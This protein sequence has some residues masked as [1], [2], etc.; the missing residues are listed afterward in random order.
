VAAEGTDEPVIDLLE[1]EWASISAL[2]A[3]LDDA[4][5][6]ADTDCPG[7][8]AKDNV[9]HLVGIENMLRG[10]PADPPVDDRPSH[11]K[12][13]FGAF[14]EAAVE[15]RRDRSGAD[16][17]AE[18]R[19]VAAER[20][21]ALR[22]L[23]AAK[24]DEVGPTPTGEDTYRHFMRMR[25]FDSWVHEQDIRRAVGVPGHLTGP[26][27][28]LVLEWHRRNLGYIV[29]RRAGVPDGSAVAFDLGAERIVVAVEG[30]RARVL[31]DGDAASADPAV[32]L[33]LDVETFNALLAGRWSADHAIAQ[34][35]L[36]V[37]G[38]TA[39]GHQV[40]AAMAYLF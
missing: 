29:G 34:D 11:V 23:P 38:D 19:S 39:L 17:L 37:T 33:Q 7:W 9:S 14:N 15:A 3:T 30:K 16:V 40:A 2:G 5:W 31:D 25:V 24:W 32:T 26:V 27:V 18:F 35:R 21:A 10:A 28:D 20:V 13:D 36:R 12:N 4:Q 6:A 22:A 1:Q 8:T